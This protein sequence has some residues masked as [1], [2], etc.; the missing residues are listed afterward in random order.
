MPEIVSVEITNKYINIHTN[1]SY[2]VQPPQARLPQAPQESLS[3]REFRLSLEK[4]WEDKEVLNL[5]NKFEKKVFGI[6]HTMNELLDF[7]GDGFLEQDDDNHLGTFWLKWY[8][9]EK[10]VAVSVLDIYPSVL[11][12]FR[13]SFDHS[14][15]RSFDHSENHSIIRSFDHSIIRSFDHSPLVLRLLLLRP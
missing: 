11:V 15:I 10:L 5:Y 7:L 1:I 13:Q 8:I 9:D 3:K 2:P 14:I 12:G 4:C 6:T